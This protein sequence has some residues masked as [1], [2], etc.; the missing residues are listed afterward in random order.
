MAER[1]GSEAEY[2]RKIRMIT[3]VLY[4][5]FA[6]EI[7]SAWEKKPNAIEAAAFTQTIV[8]GEVEGEN[9]LALQELEARAEYAKM[10][11]LERERCNEYC[12]LENHLEEEEHELSWKREQRRKAR[13]QKKRREERAILE[14][15]VE[16]EAGDQDLKGR[17]LVANVIMNRVKSS[18]FPDSVRGVVFA[19]RQFSPIANGSYYRVTVSEKTKKAVQKAVKG[20]D[21]SK[22][23]LYFMCRSASTPSN[24]AWF[25]RA[26]TKVKEY[27]CHEFFK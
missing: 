14:R 7:V 26:L 4:M 22:G 20:I 21:Y 10:K 25:D 13:E 27:G 1:F 5:V 6:V 16:A 15:I 19:H 17:I 3:T 24:V 9:Q 12:A 18:H 8:Y 11:T 2:M 23:A